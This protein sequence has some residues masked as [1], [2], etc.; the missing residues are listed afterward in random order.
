MLFICLLCVKNY[1]YF[2]WIKAKVRSLVVFNTNLSSIFGNSFAL[3]S[4]KHSNPSFRIYQFVCC[5][6]YTLLMSLIMNWIYWVLIDGK[7]SEIM[8]KSIVFHALSY[9]ELY[10]SGFSFKYNTFIADLFT[11][12]KFVYFHINRAKNHEFYTLQCKSGSYPFTF[13]T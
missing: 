5:I 9:S 13:T 10:Y 3:D 7:M 1:C 11:N 8:L 4:P 2:D 6:V 12:G